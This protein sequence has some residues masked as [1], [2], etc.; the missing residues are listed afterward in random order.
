MA[1]W[2]PEAVI[3]DQGL[4]EQLNLL[5]DLLIQPKNVLFKQSL[6]VS[7]VAYLC[8]KYAKQKQRLKICTEVQVKI[9][10]IQDL[11][12]AE[13]E[14][15]HQLVDLAQMVGLSQW[16]LLRQFK[17]H[18]GLPPHAWLIQCRLRKSLKLL[19]QGQEIAITAQLCGFSDQ[20]HFNRHF[21]KSLGCTPAQYTLHHK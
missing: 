1:P 8:S 15:E 14:K 13:P 9:K 16:Y 4:A 2:F 21:K 3:H 6:Y 19:K 11:L 5:F 18:T 20:S 12:V 7:T 17:K 10:I